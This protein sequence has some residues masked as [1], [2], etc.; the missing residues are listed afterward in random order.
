[1]PLDSDRPVRSDGRAMTGTREFVGAR[2]GSMR[3]LVV[4][5]DGPGRSA[6]IRHCERAADL[7]VIGEAEFGAAAI[8]ATRSLRP[9]VLLLNSELPDMSGFEVLR[10]VRSEPR[11]LG[12][13]VTPRADHAVT[14][15]AAGAF[16]YLLD[17]VSS[18]RF[19]QAMA[20]ARQRLD[21]VGRDESA[22]PRRGPLPSIGALDAWRFPPPRFLVGERRHRLYPLELSKI[23]YIESDGNYV[24]IRS[25]GA[26]YLSR[27]SIK[28]LSVALSDHGF[29]RIE[30]SLL[31][32]VGAV[33]YVESAG[34]GS[35]AFTLA[36]GACL[37]S[38]VTYRD[39]ILRVLPLSQRGGRRTD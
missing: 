5:Q 16:D 17:P 38:G 28:R 12:I 27:D 11:P 1:M 23:D 39:G 37:H 19:D 15:F 29:V 4:G 14:A 6:L 10:A 36:C 9:D 21:S 26:E 30:R 25:G 22:Q 7:E 20:R 34:H 33:S 31:V 3:F 8:E 13:I 24:T 32:N 18:H 2:L 35:Y